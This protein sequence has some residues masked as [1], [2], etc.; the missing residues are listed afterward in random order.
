[1]SDS[2]YSSDASSYIDNDTMGGGGR[3]RRTRPLSDY[4]KF[5]QKTLKQLRKTAENAGKKPVQ[6]TLMKQA[7]ALWQ[8][9]K[10][11][12]AKTTKRIKRT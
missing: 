12:T 3:R 10:K 5:M 2:E 4:N 8:K 1:M 11:K 7:A 6:T 9:K